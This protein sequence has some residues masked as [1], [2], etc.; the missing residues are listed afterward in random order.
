MKLVDI[1]KIKKDIE[2][3]LIE[4]KD[5]DRDISNLK[6]MK[7]NARDRLEYLITISSKQIEMEFN[8]KN[9]D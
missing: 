5:I 1:D 9:T 3:I 7:N 4:I 8:E 2:K 6:S